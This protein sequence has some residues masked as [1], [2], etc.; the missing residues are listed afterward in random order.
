MISAIAKDAGDH[1]DVNTALRGS[2]G[3]IEAEA[4]AILK[5]IW[6]QEHGPKMID[7]ILGDFVDWCDKQTKE[8]K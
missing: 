8:D 2:G 7:S 5:S 1:Y 3:E 4:R 6:G